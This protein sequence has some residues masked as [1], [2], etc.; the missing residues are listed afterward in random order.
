VTFVLNKDK[1]TRRRALQTPQGWNVA[2]FF[3]ENME[4]MSGTGISQTHT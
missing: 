1:R 4:N 2:A 3:L